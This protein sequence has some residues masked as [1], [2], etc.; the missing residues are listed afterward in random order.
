MRGINVLDRM[1]LLPPNLC[2]LI[3]RDTS[4]KRKPLT[5]EQIAAASGL[6]V[7]EVQRISRHTSWDKVPFGSMMRFMVGCGVTTSNF[8]KHLAYVKSTARTRRPLCHLDKTDLTPGEL[9]QI[10]SGSSG[11]R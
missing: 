4:S 10:K 1:N 7:G 9:V 11:R 3:A 2:R 6:T 8:H 5:T